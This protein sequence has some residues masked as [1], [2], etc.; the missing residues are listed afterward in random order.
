LSTASL[1]S[2]CEPPASMEEIEKAGKAPPL[3]TASAGLYPA[4]RNTTFEYQRPESQKKDVLQYTNFYEFAVTKDSWQRVGAFK[5]T[6]W[7]VEVT[8][9]CS[10]PQTFDLDDLH[11]EFALEERCYRHRCV[12][13][14]AM[15]VPW[16]GFTLA[17]LLKKVE[18][19]PSARYV[20]FDTFFRPGEAPGFDAHSSFPWP[21][22]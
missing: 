11:R 15:C 17:E 14:W 13:T 9:L 16:T 12:E 6:P 1:F 8:G 19:K 21:Y 10:K 5:P 20:A 4:K 22:K 3:P 2:G 18:P 7:S